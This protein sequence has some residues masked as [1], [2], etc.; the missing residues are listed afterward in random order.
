MTDVPTKPAFEPEASYR[1]RVVR[2]IWMG[3]FRYL[4]RDEPTFTGSMLNQIVE[5]HGA[6]VLDY[7]EPV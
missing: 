5:E 7:A 2:P 1:A 4:P 3:A 6:D